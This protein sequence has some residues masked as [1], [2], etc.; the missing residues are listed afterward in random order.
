MIYQ[1][2]V[3]YAFLHRDGTTGFGSA[4]ASRPLPLASPGDVT[5]MS[6][7]IAH[8]QGLDKVIVLNVL[9]FGPSGGADEGEGEA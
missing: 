6:R 1:Y 8:D 2:H 5:E 9:A 4:E 7:Q 3:S